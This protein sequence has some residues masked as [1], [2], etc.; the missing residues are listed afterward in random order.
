MKEDVQVE[1]APKMKVS[2]GILKDTDPL[3]KCWNL[4][5]EFLDEFVQF[6]F[7]IPEIVQ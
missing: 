1:I 3:E 4:K 5:G 7:L 2:E 6:S